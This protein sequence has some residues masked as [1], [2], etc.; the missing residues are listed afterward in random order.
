VAALTLD[1][2]G[3]ARREA[4]RLC[5]DSSA[6]RLAARQNLRVA[7]ARKER[8]EIVTIAATYAQAPA[9]ATSPWSQ[10]LWLR[11]DDDLNRVLVRV[12]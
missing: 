4:R 6:L 9:P 7:A 5:G 8:A 1:A 11:P 10:L 12:A 2:A 3:A